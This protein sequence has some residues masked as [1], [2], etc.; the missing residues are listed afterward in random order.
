MGQLGPWLGAVVESGCMRV[1]MRQ[2]TPTLWA[3]VG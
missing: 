3:A 2:S 1:L